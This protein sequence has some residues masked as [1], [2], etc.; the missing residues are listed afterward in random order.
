[1]IT[2][3]YFW[4]IEGSRIIWAILR[5]ALDRRA[6]KGNRAIKFWKLLGTGKGETFTPRDADPKRWGLLITIDESALEAFEGSKMMQRWSKNSTAQFSATLKTIAVHG[7]WSRKNPFKSEVAPLDWN[8]KV[9]AITRARIKWRK[10]L[11][12]WRSVPPVTASLKAAPGLIKAIGIGEAPIGLQGT[13]SIWEDPKTIS[14]FAYRGE[15]HKAA[16][17]ATAR[18][19]WYAEE[20]FARFAL[21]DSR[22]EL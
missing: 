13:F 16:I 9:V 18:E 6:L 17:A 12:F 8:G 2:R 11:L 21:I 1:M 10:N 4:K 15:A 20:M 5:M 22:G 7:K 3:I 14:Y 19:K